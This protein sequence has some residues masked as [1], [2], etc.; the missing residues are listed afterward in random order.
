MDYK[1]NFDSESEE[2]E[3]HSFNSN[4]SYDDEQSLKDLFDIIH[5]DFVYDR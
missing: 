4:I 5:S 3:D 1:F 2:S